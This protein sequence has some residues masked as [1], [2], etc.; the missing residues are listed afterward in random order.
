MIPSESLFVN[1]IVVMRTGFS[2]ASI[3]PQI[4]I[5]LMYHFLAEFDAPPPMKPPDMEFRLTLVGFSGCALSLLSLSVSLT[6]S[7]H[8]GDRLRDSFLA[9]PCFSYSSFVG[10]ALLPSFWTYFLTLLFGCA[11]QLIVLR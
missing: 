9:R 5:V 2:L 10:L 3:I 1:V 11:F 8:V 4:K 6:A 7:C